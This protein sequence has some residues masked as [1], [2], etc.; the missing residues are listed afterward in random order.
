MSTKISSIH[1][2]F[3]QYFNFQGLKFALWGMTHPVVYKP[4]Y[5]VKDISEI[6]WSALKSNGIKYVVFDKDNTLTIPYESKFYPDIQSSIDECKSV[7]DYNNIVI[8]SNSA[9]SKDDRDSSDGKLSW[10]TIF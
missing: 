9:G 1:H 5:S 6:D 3:G 7:Y 10:K 2:K 8:L 4:H